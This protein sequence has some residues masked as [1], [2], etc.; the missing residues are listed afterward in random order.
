MVGKLLAAGY[1]LVPVPAEADIILV[2]TCAFIRPAVEESVEEILELARFKTG[3]CRFM[4]V[5]GCLTPR[6]GRVLKD[7]LPEVDLFLGPGD[8]P[9]LVERLTS[10]ITKGKAPYRESSS[11]YL[12]THEE[13]QWIPQT[14][15]A[16]LK[17]AEGCSN[18]CSYC[19]IP[20][21]RG[22]RRSRTPDDILQEAEILVQA[23]I[24][25]IVLVAQ[26]TTAY[27][28][29]LPGRPTLEGLLKDVT[30]LPSVSWVRLLYAHPARVR[31][32]LLALMAEEE[33][34]CAYLDLPIQ[35]AD[36]H[37]LQAMNRRYRSMDV[38]RFITMARSIVPQVAIRTSIMVGFPGETDRRFAKLVDFIRATRFDHLGV[39]TYCAEEGA[40]S[41]RLGSRKVPQRVK[42]E[43]KRIIEEEQAVISWEIHQ[44]LVGTEQEILVEGMSDDA[45]FPYQGRIRRQAPE[46]DGVTYMRGPDVAIGRIMKGRIV[47]ADTYDLFAEIPQPQTAR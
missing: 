39:F 42:D 29:D 16:Y 18:H 5:T 31:K 17:I 1:D 12:M 25:E 27:G 40:Q 45:A 26:D 47:G 30:S 43:R 20:R 32:E 28:R 11:P 23:G 7:V 33:K 3:Q 37:I 22:R 36:D 9:S 34:L 10:L 15:S 8:I 2:N 4:V 14:P 6:Y 19:L 13:R 24:K 38:S 41:T 21:L 35:H 46:I 44:S